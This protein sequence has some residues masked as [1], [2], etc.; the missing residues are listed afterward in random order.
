[1]KRATF[2]ECYEDNIFGL[3]ARCR[4]YFIDTRAALA[5]GTLGEN[6]V[7]SDILRKFTSKGY[8]YEA[9]LKFIQSL[10]NELP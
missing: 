5:N 2:D 9:A 6:T 8:A 10:K 1:M 4:N 3:Q 7:E